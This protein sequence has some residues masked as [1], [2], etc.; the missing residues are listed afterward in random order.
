MISLT[1]DP[2]DKSKL[3]LSATVTLFLDRVLIETLNEE[4]ASQITTQARKDIKGNPAV[5][6]VIAEAAQKKLLEMLGVP[7]ATP[8]S[9]EQKQ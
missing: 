6:K 5:K 2:N 1:Q 4:V 3:I 8:A 7:E 9:Q